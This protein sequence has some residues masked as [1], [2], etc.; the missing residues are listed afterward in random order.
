MSSVSD[1]TELASS[2]V[3]EHNFPTNSPT[4]VNTTNWKQIPGTSQL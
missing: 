3:E 1:L 2:A 4:E